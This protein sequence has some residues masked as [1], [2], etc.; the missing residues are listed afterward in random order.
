MSTFFAHSHLKAPQNR[1]VTISAKKLRHLFLNFQVHNSLFELC[2][3][4][5]SEKY[6]TCFT[7]TVEYFSE[8]IPVHNSKSELCTWK[9]KNKYL[10]FFAEIVTCLFCVSGF[11]VFSRKF[12]FQ[13]FTYQKS[14]Q[15]LGN[16]FVDP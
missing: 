2:T 7:T 9:F 3:G 6:S 13:F 8:N 4:I 14:L 11:W 16:L 10:S 12:H 15:N 5:F 1:H